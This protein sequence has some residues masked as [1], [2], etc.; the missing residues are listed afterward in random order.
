[1]FIYLYKTRFEQRRKIVQMDSLFN[2]VRRSTRLSAATEEKWKSVCSVSSLKKGELL[3]RKG[4]YCRDFFFV[5]EG[6]VKLTFDKGEGEFIMRFFEE[7]Y[8]LTEVESLSLNKASKYEIRA[9]EDTR[10]IRFSNEALETLSKEDPNV[11]LFYTRFLKMAHINMMNRISEMLEAD[12]KVRYTNFLEQQSALI[13]RISL[14]DLSSYLGI[15]QVTLS[16]IR[17]Q[18]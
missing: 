16:R 10:V 7:N 12:A 18:S 1:M 2:F 6:L 9:L 11:G 13:N 17:K 14:G 8:L 3:L 5:E 15:N 4:S